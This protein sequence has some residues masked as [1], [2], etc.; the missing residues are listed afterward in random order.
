M[1]ALSPPNDLP[2]KQP[3]LR[4]A[5]G[6]MALLA[7]L[8]FVSRADAQSGDRM[9]VPLGRNNKPTFTKGTGLQITVD[10]TWA[11][12]RG[13][14]PVTVI[15]SMAAAATADTQLTIRFY[16][17]TW[18]SHQAISVE[19]DFELPQGAASVTSTF[20][21]PQYVDWN[22]FS[23]DIW[24]DG[25]KDDYLKL[26]PTG[27]N[28][29][30]NSTVAVG[31]FDLGTASQL[32][33]GGT[34]LVQAATSSAVGEQI[35]NLNNLPESWIDYSPL[36]VVTTTVDALELARVSSPEKL[37]AL[38]RWVRAGGNLW[39]LGVGEDF[40]ALPEL[41]QVLAG[42]SSNRATDEAADESDWRFLKLSSTGRT[43]L[44]DVTDLI[45]DNRASSQVLSRSD[46]TDSKF[47]DVAV[48]SRRWFVA[49]QFGL[50]TILALENDESLRI[51]Q[52]APLATAL[53]RSAVTENLTWSARH[54]NDP[55]TGNP[56]FNNWLIADVGAAPVFEFQLLIS[57]FVIG[58]GPVNYWLLKRRNQLPLLLL[59]VPIA[60]LAATLML[61]AYGFLA[62]GI[63]TRLRA[64]SYTILDQQAGEV[65]TW[66]RMSYYAGIAPSD[67]LVVPDDTTLYPM[68]PSRSEYTAFGRRQVNQQRSL[69]WTNKQRLTRG[70]L[71]SRTP[72][73]YLTITARPSAKRL[74]FQAVA[75]GLQVRNQLGTSVAMLIAQ[76]VDGNIFLG[77]GIDAEGQAILKAANYLEAASLLRRLMTENLPQLPPGYVENNRGRRS[78]DFGNAF[79]ESLMELQLEAISSPQAT[80]WGN[81]TFIAVTADGIE[82]PRGLDD[83]EENNSFH[84]VRGTW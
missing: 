20:S 7:G 26:H 13:Y 40:A 6:V 28:S 54:G 16:A 62:D 67:G 25:V 50:G 15:A 3:L 76:D 63:E 69:E 52:N 51:G 68:L 44:I 31:R 53:Q 78:R 79:S 58:I 61:F 65:A 43:R 84:V 70:W 14:R 59:T 49:R 36:D 27:F 55:A 41:N 48:D 35:L 19:H 77:E 21:V 30:S 64:R 80:G 42:E 5:I 60:A 71:G 32:N 33:R 22:S 37:T 23:W 83:L 9:T 12:N 45:M 39:V 24:V 56:N 29:G 11:G 1:T 74:D 2:S 34:S 82:L 10:T 17:G 38:L 72:T 8:L 66:S 47:A 81:R 18:R 75:D 57:L 4:T 46:L 73:Q